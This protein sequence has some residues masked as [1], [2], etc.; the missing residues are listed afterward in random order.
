MKVFSQSHL[1]GRAKIWMEKKR[2]HREIK[3][4]DTAIRK[5]K[6]ADRATAVEGIPN[7]QTQESVNGGERR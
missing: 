1:L 4:L 6:R 2:L 7:S 3:K 5:S